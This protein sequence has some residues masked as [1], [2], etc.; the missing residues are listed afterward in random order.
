MVFYIIIIT[1][2][3]TK[4]RARRRDP[5]HLVRGKRRALLIV[6]DVW[7]EIA[8]R[9]AAMR[10]GVDHRVVR[11]HGQR[12]RV[13]QARRDAYAVANRLIRLGGRETP[14]AAG[15]VELGTWVA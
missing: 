7:P 9:V 13:V 5:D 2:R 4:I 12:D 14:D 1:I 3:P 10:H 8:Q 6:I 15:D 11:A